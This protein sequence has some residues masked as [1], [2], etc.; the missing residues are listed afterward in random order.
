MFFIKS[1]VGKFC[2]EGYP[3]RIDPDNKGLLKDIFRLLFVRNL[4]ASLCEPRLTT[5]ALLLGRKPRDIICTLPEK[6]QDIECL[7]LKNA[8]ISISFISYCG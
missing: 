2:G 5:L 8:E 4:A 1:S 3:S 7:A 6:L